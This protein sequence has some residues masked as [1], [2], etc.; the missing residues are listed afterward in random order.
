MPTSPFWESNYRSGRLPW[1]LGGPAPVFARLA[2]SGDFPPGRMIVP[3]AGTG[4]DARLFARHG[5][6]VTAVDFAPGAAR[7]MRALQDPTAP[8]IILRAD[9]FALPPALLG[10]F[11][12]VLEYTCVCAL[13]PERRV[14]YADVIAQLLRPGGRY[15]GLLWPTGDRP[16]GPPFTV[17]PDEMVNLF[18][19]RG[20]TLLHR[21]SPPDSVAARRGEEELI[22]LAKH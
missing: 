8:L 22:I 5:F 13:E 11:D 4:H 16:G 6:R 10:M 20:L 3:G 15:L 18:Q 1:D 9:L 7:A 21:E 2:A 17:R 19:S 14:A 12:Y